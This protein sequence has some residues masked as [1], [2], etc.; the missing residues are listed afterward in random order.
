MRRLWI[1]LLVI[2]CVPALAEAQKR[3]LLP[4]DYYRITQVG[5][6]AIHGAQRDLEGLGQALRSEGGTAATQCMDQQEES[7]GAAHAA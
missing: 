5:D 7:V 3:G 6:V 1:G 2:G 4:Q